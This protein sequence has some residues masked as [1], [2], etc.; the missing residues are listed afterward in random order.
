[1]ITGDY[2]LNEG[3]ILQL[4][5]A[6]PEAGDHDTLSVGGTLTAEGNLTVVL[7]GGFTPAGGD[8][9]NL[10]SFDTVSGSFASVDL[11]ALPA[12]LAWSN[13]LLA[14]GLLQVVA[15]LLLGDAN[16]DLQVTGADLITAQQNFGGTGP[17]DGLL[18][19]DANDDGLVTGQDLIAVQQNFGATL[20]APGAA[21]VPEPVVG[22]LLGLGCVA[23]RRRR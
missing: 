8:T 2:A 11:P 22:W 13:R 14:E 12:G 9:F 20:T 10:L 7:S 17:A 4:D 18:L 19:G 21:L 6:G 1:M 3:G 23:L 16:N 5:L 15:A